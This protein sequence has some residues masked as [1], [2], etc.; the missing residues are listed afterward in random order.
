MKIETGREISPA[1]SV[2]RLEEKFHFQVEGLERLKSNF[3]VRI[4]EYYARLIQEPGDAIWKQCVPSAVELED[5]GLSWD[6]LGEDV[7]GHHP[8]PGLVHKYPDRAL[9]MVT[10]KCPMYC[11]F[12]TRKRIT[13][14]KSLE[15]TDETLA[16]ALEY[17]RAHSE[18]R[19]VILS[20]GEPLMLPAQQLRYILQELK[21]IP[22]LQW[23]RIHTKMPCV[24]P[25]QV[26]AEVAE[27]I[28]SAHPVFV[29][30]HFNH[31][32]EL[33]PEAGAACQRLA[34]H[35]IQLGSHT[36]LLKGIN[37]DLETLK[38]LFEGLL[39]FRVRPYY[40]LLADPCHGTSHFRTRLE[41]A[42]KLMEGLRGWCSGM[43]VPQL[44][45]E[46]TEGHG[47]VPVVPDY[48]TSIGTD[49]VQYQ[50][51]DGT[52]LEYPQPQ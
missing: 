18:L 2:Q 38:K 12:C 48:V 26:T 52:L 31:P 49:R 24:D 36:V 34:D 3:R 19:E 8:V 23:L 39:R 33:T 43:M 35:G 28:A 7:E 41:D 6:P 27:A 9:L 45:M 25:G 4:P 21:A 46:G 13:H 42:L 5:D 30:V 47:K 20:G 1:V 14:T 22:H 16:Q 29:H 32:R 40:L 15:L 10:D 37:D 50:S 44:M 51:Y 11:R 17:I